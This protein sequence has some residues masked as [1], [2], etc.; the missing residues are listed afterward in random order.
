MRRRSA[1]PVEVEAAAEAVARR[2]ARVA[3]IACCFEVWT[4]VREYRVYGY[5]AGAARG[6]CT[7]LHNHPIQKN[8]KISRHPEAR[9]RCLLIIPPTLSLCANIRL[10]TL[11]ADHKKPL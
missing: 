2:A 5:G 4:V 6:T 7:I 3:R 10:T 1:A 8:E 11:E 9:P